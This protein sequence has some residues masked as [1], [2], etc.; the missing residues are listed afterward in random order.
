M[1]GPRTNQGG[2]DPPGPVNFPCVVNALAVAA[3]GQRWSLDRRNTT[4]KKRVIMAQIFIT[5]STDGLGRMAA[6][7]LIARGH[8]VITHARN[9]ARA[10]DAPAGALATVVGDVGTLAGMRAVAHQVNAL[11]RANAVIHNVAIGYREKR[12]VLTDDGLP[13]VFATNVL[14]PYVLTALIERPERLIYL[15]SE[16]HR[17]VKGA[18]D[19][20][21][22]ETRRWNGTAAYAETKFHDVLLAFA[23][24]RLWPH[25]RANAL[26]PGWVPTKMGGPRARGDLTKAHLT[27]VRLAIGDDALAATTGGYFF[28]EAPREAHPAARDLNLQD[29]LLSR[30]A[31]L[32][33]VRIAG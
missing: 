13:Q 32:S 33:G 14:A 1:P 17:T 28:H 19:D 31:E 10:H 24:A 12:R 18:L 7:L 30:C 23:I 6:E 26:E 5:G 27:Q 15:S 21:L 22:W 3:L 11:G 25:V 8:R 29:Q 16:L 2:D 4:F 20:L 9:P